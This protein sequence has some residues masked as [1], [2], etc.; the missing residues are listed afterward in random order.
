MFTLRLNYRTKYECQT[1]SNITRD[2][3]VLTLNSFFSLAVT[4]KKPANRQPVSQSLKSG[5]EKGHIAGQSGA[6]SD[7]IVPLDQIRA[8][9]SIQ[10]DLMQLSD[11]SPR[12]V[13]I[14]ITGGPFHTSPLQVQAEYRGGIEGAS[15]IQWYR[16]PQWF[17]TAIPN[18]NQPA[19]Q[20]TAEDVNTRIRVEYTPVRSDGVRGPTVVEMVPESFLV[21]DPRLTGAVEQNI[22]RGSAIFEVAVMD[23]PTASE[24][25]LLHLTQDS[26]QL[27]KALFSRPG[28]H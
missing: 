6:P 9:A 25:C 4:L 10:Q 2:I 21:I 24:L 23:Q 11:D 12:I 19:F 16:W 26:L 20:P 13:N 27:Q 3:I 28:S 17:F 8:E 5:E 7:R 18:A 15:I 14:E 22:M 1:D